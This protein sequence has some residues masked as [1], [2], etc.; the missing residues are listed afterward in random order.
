MGLQ[1]L[2]GSQDG[3]WLIIDAFEEQCPFALSKKTEKQRFDLD[4]WVP[5]SAGRLASR[6]LNPGSTQ[7]SGPTLA[8]IDLQLDPLC[9][10][11]LWISTCLHEDGR[12]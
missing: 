6:K 7:L 8:A 1:I 12:R 3:P 10:S 5:I 4:G 2:D 11:L 9:A